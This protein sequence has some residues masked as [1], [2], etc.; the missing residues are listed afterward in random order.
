[1]VYFKMVPFPPLPA[2][3][4]RRFFSDI[5]CENLVKL[6]DV[7]FTVWDPHDWVLLEFLP[8]RWMHAEPLAIHQL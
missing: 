4:I 8:F 5:H 3:S 2:R 1:M 7:K 6:L